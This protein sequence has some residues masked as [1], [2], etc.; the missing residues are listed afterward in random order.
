MVAA[1]STFIFILISEIELFYRFIVRDFVYS[2]EEVMAGKNELSKLE[3]DKKKQFVSAFL[4]VTESVKCL[5][6]LF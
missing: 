6:V 3:S 5:A 1:L 4:S 2:E